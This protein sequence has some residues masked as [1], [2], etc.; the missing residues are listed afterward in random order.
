MIRA[1]AGR[2]R[3]VLPPPLRRAARAVLLAWGWLTADLRQEPDIVVVG[4]QR[5]G[6]TTLFRL[7][8]EHPDLCRPTVDKG[9][10]YFDD[11]YRHGRR[12]YRAHFPL[13]RTARGRRT[14]ECSGYYLFHPLAADRLAR[15]LPG[16]QVVALVRDPV[17]RAHSAHRH[18]SARGF[19]NL[20]FAD[21][22]A[23]EAVRTA[24]QAH[25]LVTDP[26][27]ASFAHRHHAYLQ[28]GEYAV[29]L[30]RY[31]TALGRERVHVVDAGALFADPVGVYVDLQ[32]RLGLTV[33]RPDE[34]GRWNERPGDPLPPDL[35]AALRRRFDGPDAALA[36][37]LGRTPSW[38]EEASCRDPRP[39]ACDAT[40]ER[41]VGG[42]AV[43]RQTPSPPSRRRLADAPLWRRS[44]RRP[45]TDRGT[46]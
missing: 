38:R 29:Q 35:A 32:R 14:F 12:W 8:S 26:G 7:L 2:L 36:E 30:A 16:C 39:G 9:T 37:L 46:K 19:E 45:T 24:G 21:A 42:V 18:E 28:R 22:V 5:A 23:L 27:A 13:R 33:H 31:V 43:A 11:G 10:G 4:A 20:P 1:L 25:L 15:D 41:P 44:Q 17:A 3:P 34:V 40:P 6:T